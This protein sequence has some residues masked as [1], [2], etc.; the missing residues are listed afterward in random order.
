MQ[1][2]YDDFQVFALVTMFA[3]AVLLPMVVLL[4]ILNC[5]LLAKVSS[6]PTRLDMQNGDNKK[7]NAQAAQQ[8]TQ[9]SAHQ[10]AKQSAQTQSIKHPNASTQQF[11]HYDQ[12]E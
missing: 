1:Q 4:I 5:A 6:L 3:L 11:K 2:F 8:P 12:Y 9:P 10:S 7:S